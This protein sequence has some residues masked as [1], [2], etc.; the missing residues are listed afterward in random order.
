M[1]ASDGPY[2][3][4]LWIRFRIEARPEAERTTQLAV[5]VVRVLVRHAVPPGFFSLVEHHDRE[6]RKKAASALLSIARKAETS[7]RVPSLEQ[8]LREARTRLLELE[9]AL[10]AARA[11]T[12]DLAV[13]SLTREQQSCRLQEQLDQREQELDGARENL[14][15]KELFIGSLQ[16][17][18]EELKRKAQ[19][20]AFDASSRTAILLAISGKPTPADAL[21]VVETLFPK[22]VVVLASAMKS[23][24]AS[25]SFA[26]GSR[27]LD[28]LL[29]LAG[30]Y[31][32]MLRRAGTGDAVAKSVFGSAF[33]AVESKTTMDNDRARRERTFPYRGASRT[34]WRH[35]R[36]GTKDSI[37]ESIRVHFD[38]VDDEQRVVIGHCGEHLFLPLK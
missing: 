21:R 1:S 13:E 15:S 31:C 34:M 12:D 7:D 38:W 2:Q 20:A 19:A 29:K 33:A 6:Q 36:I 8:S 18:C 3:H 11:D 22:R 26:Y 28:L 5:D 4:P 16:E 24:H 23:A 32:D 35:L 17:T 25:E 10:R 14:R 37:T 27:L 30:E 9:E